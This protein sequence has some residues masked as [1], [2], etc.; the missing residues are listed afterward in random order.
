MQPSA[1]CWRVR[2]AAS[3]KYEKND[4]HAQ[5]PQSDI[6]SVIPIPAPLLPAGKLRSEVLKSLDFPV[7]ET[8]SGEKEKFLYPDRI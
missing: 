5:D 2:E 3:R 1:Q 6:S 8:F 4:G 7:G